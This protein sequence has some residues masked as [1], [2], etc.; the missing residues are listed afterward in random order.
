MGMSLR[1]FE[2]DYGRDEKRDCTSMLM[3]RLWR[4]LGFGCEYEA[5]GLDW[6]SLGWEC[7][8]G[9]LRYPCSRIESK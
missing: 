3:V 6:T 1:G 5:F 2:S 4:W 8:T 7:G 9:V